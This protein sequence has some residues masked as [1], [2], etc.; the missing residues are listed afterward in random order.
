[1]ALSGADLQRLL[2]LSK[3]FG[4]D[5]KTLTGLFKTLDSHTTSSDS[6]WTGKFANDFRSDW[7]SL[8]PSL[9]KFVNLLDEASKATKKHYDNISAATGDH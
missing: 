4:T 8:K 6:Y 2:D 9:D 5:H 3:L 7:A 1:M